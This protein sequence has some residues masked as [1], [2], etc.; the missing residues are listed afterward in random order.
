MSAEV[1][2]GFTGGLKWTFARDDVT[3][4]PP[5]VIPPFG[6]VGDMYAAMSGLGVE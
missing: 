5:S 1:T 3:V 6:T 2:A 4:L